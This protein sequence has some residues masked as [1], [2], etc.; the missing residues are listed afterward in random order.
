MTEPARLH[1]RPDLE[2]LRAV[3]VVLVLLYHAGVPG[4]GGGYVGVDVFFVLS[5]FLITGLIDRE[6][7]ATGTFSFATFYARRARRL[8]PAA[9]FVL[10]V[11]L[12]ASV[13]ILPAY[14]LPAIRDD[15]V[16]AGLY[17]SNLRFGLAETDYFQAIADPSPVLHYWSLSVEEQF[18]VLWPAVLVGLSVGLAG[19][20]GLGAM[21]GAAGRG[22]RVALGVFGIGL[23]SLVAAAWLTGV[24]QPWAFYLLP[25]R[26]WELAAGGLVALGLARLR[27]LTR[28]AGAIATVI[29]IGAIVVAALR[30]DESTATPG[31]P[32]LLPAAGALL[33]IVGGLPS[34]VPGPSRLLA[35]APFRFLGRISYSL[36]LWHWPILLLGTTVV[37][38]GWGIPL[39]LLAV[40]VAAASHRWIEEPFRHGRF[41]GTMPRA[42]LLQAAGVGLAVI[43]T[44]AGVAWT[45]GAN[46]GAPP[47]AA[48]G[49]GASTGSVAPSGGAEPSPA[50]APAPPSASV[51]GDPRPCSNCSLADL[52]PP[53][54]D[55]RAGRI[56]DGAC[57]VA[58]PD[59]CVL[60]STRP[61][62]TTIALF[63]DSHA[64][65]WTAVLAALATEHDW[66]FVHLTLGG[67][68][69]ADAQVWSLTLRRAV[70]EC[71]AWRQQVLERLAVEQPA[72]IIVANSEHHALVSVDGARVA[73]TN[74][75]S[76]SWLEL[77]SG[78]LD[79]MLGRLTT[80]GGAVALVADQ[81]VPEW[82]NV[83]PIA[84]IARE[85]ADFA[86][87]DADR[88]QALPS[89]V[90]ELEQP[91]VA[92]HDVTF[93]DPSPW[94]C[95]A[96][97]CPAVIDRYVVYL[98]DSGHLTAAFAMSLKER[99]QSAVP[100]PD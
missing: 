11:T 71:D 62:A 58:D 98:D 8:L 47:V 55:L 10:I 12:V 28:P 94:L 20:A 53:L 61:G 48:G 9:G 46:A 66:R 35:L 64:G 60:G 56:P 87:C 91:I 89:T 57:S 49:P 90:R 80:I 3:A 31:I 17:V 50:G 77:W 6:L 84:C 82:A 63:G 36:Y 14:R 83:D 1:F 39:A 33:V 40:P 44:S 26:A 97:R 45:G 13:L 32:A 78:G 24:S 69:A 4:F 29:G 99:L 2:G 100:F 38:P 37:G 18:Y 73:Y 19:L 22:R 21:A 93:V 76:A 7:E 23:L 70:P 74:P 79:R 41:I 5:G 72:L 81:P 30:F 88:T 65:S 75:P 42:N 52:T 15:V 67:C 16:S 54:T 96:E 92:A 59:D 85:P 27:A 43:L 34:P 25:T 51:L 86:S 95:S 68:P